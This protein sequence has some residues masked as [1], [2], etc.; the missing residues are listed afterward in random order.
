MI[1][2]GLKFRTFN[3]CGLTLFAFLL[4]PTWARPAAS[5]ADNATIYYRIKAGDHLTRILREQLNFSDESKLQ[6][7]TAQ[8]N[9]L[10]PGRQRWDNLREGEL[11]RLPV[12]EKAPSPTEPQRTIELAAA[13]PATPPSLTGQKTAPGVA[14]TATP[15][16]PTQPQTPPA[17]LLTLDDA[18]LIALA[19]HPNLSAAR[20]R[21][22]AQRAVVGQQM[23]AYF[24]TLTMTDRYQTGNQ[25]GGSN[26]AASASDFFSVQFSTTFTLYNFGKREGAVQAARETLSAQGHNF[27]T[28]TDAVVLG[29][30]TAY[31][32]YLQARAIVNVREESVKSRD[33]L[34][35][36]ARGF[37]EV[38]TRARIDV[39]R[40]ESDYFTALADE[41]T[42]RNA[43]QVAWVTL[44][45]ALGLRDLPDRPL[46]EE[47]IVTDIRY[48]SNEARELA[49]QTRPELKSFEAQLRAQDQNIAVARRGHLPDLTFDGNY[50]R[51]HVSNEVVNKNTVNTFP[52]KPS[53]QVQLTL[54]LPIFDG[55]RTTNR[56]DETLHNYSVIKAQEEQQRQQVALDVEQS[57]LR[58][59]ELRE[60]IKANEAAAKAARENL[61]LARGRYE[62]GVGSIIEVSDAQVRYADAQTTYVRALYDY[63]IADAQFTRAIGL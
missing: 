27:K 37:F 49:Y 18:L 51:R 14:S 56:V 46:A 12:Q 31:Y 9:Q 45:N 63:K 3:I 20:E 10:N 7:Y 21:I 50:A 48:S 34:L 23:A 13:A 19:N 57:Y 38:G 28:T 17:N 35:K 29:V 2:L 33:L 6:Q 22:Y 59:V 11:I 24:P 26:I 1:G 58:L 4:W 55:L 42:A 47:A 41:I 40:A 39:A 52:L 43:V 44:K 32:G 61:D 36:Q 5:P 16:E 53:W 62:V 30:K 15:T 8:L 60:R 25:S 54:S